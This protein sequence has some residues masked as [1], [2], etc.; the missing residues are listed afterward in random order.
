MNFV[1]LSRTCLSRRLLS[2]SPVVKSPKIDASKF[3]LADGSILLCSSDVS[4]VNNKFYRLIKW[5][6]LFVLLLP[7][8]LVWIERDDFEWS[9]MY[10]E[11]HDY[12]FGSG[13]H[14]ED[15]AYIWDSIW[16]SLV[17]FVTYQ[18]MA[19]II[20]SA[21]RTRLHHIYSRFCTHIFYNE[22]RR[23]LLFRSTNVQMKNAHWAELPVGSVKFV[24]GNYNA[25]PPSVS[26]WNRGPDRP[27]DDINGLI[28]F[29]EGGYTHVVAT[30]TPPDQPD[31]KT[32]LF[33][34][35]QVH[36]EGDIIYFLRNGSLADK[37][38]FNE[39]FRKFNVDGD[40]SIITIETSQ[41]GD[42]KTNL[43]REKIGYL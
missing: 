5:K 43:K 38:I 1:R 40:P 10:Y 29:S 2:R 31:W 41:A 13:Y 23:M 25:P 16:S 15:V 36:N 37:D 20:Y 33:T 17:N 12:Y 18:I 30:E 27:G 9:T 6:R 14:S 22:E 39:Y 8:I 7:F 26:P 42:Q 4:V 19:F 21:Y 24:C 3:T 28:Y 32:Q 35:R 34:S 11:L